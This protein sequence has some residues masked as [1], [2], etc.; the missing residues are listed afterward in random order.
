MM[1]A[2]TPLTQWQRQILRGPHS[3][4]GRIFH[5]IPHAGVFDV[6]GPRG[7]LWDRSRSGQSGNGLDG[8]GD[9]I[10]DGR[11]ALDRL[12]QQVV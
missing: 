12:R 6:R 9:G 10:G 1:T 11:R 7:F 2:Q 4:L 5:K 3:A 8:S